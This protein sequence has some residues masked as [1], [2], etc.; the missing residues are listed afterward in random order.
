[1]VAVF[2]GF[3]VEFVGR[4]GQSVFGVFAVFDVRTATWVVWAEGESFVIQTLGTTFV[5]AF[6]L[7]KKPILGWVE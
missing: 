6:A 4:A 3:A 2:A 1:M 5:W 7:R